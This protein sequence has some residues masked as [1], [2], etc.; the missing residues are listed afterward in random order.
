MTT[1]VL[2]RS[3][4]T[5]K[6]HVPFCRAVEEVTLSLTLITFL[7]VLKQ[8]KKLDI[9]SLKSVVISSRADLLVLVLVLKK[10]KYI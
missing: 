8:A 5:R 7:L 6:C 1:A 3:G 9:L 10:V 2:L 4:M